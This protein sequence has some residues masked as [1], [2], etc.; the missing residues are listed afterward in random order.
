MQLSNRTTVTVRL[1]HRTV[2]R[3]LQPP[4]GDRTVGTEYI[5]PVTAN[6]APL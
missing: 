6:L 2:T 1:T 5:R 3:K 4:P